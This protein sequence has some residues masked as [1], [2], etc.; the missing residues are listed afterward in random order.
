MKSALA[1]AFLALLVS[2]PMPAATPVTA[3][4]GDHQTLVV[5]GGCFWCLD[6]AYRLVPGVI[7]VESGYS[8]GNVTEP[9]YQQVCGGKTGHAEVVRITFD[10]GKV[11]LETLFALFWK[12]HDPTTLNRQGVDI[13]TQYRSVIFYQGED[14]RAIAA[15]AIA[16]EQ[17]LLGEK[18]VTQLEPLTTFWRAEEYHQDYFRKNPDQGYCQAVVRPKVDKIRK[19]LGKQPAN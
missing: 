14:Q 17:A 9:S 11:S 12:V 16:N 2:L 5:G 4:S 7:D 13:G 8:G 10:P 1:F 15:K 3:P 18:V 6:G 19:L